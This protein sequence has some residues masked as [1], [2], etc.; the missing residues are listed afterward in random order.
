VNDGGDGAQK[1]RDDRIRRE[2]LRGGGEEGKEKERSIQSN[3]QDGI[4][5]ASAS[6]HASSILTP[7]HCKPYPSSSLLQITITGERGAERD[8]ER[9]HAQAAQ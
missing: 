6:L 8:R 5:P 4:T 3:G 2:E 9:S 7:F 1:N